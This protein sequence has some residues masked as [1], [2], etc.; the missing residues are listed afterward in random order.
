M[1]QRFQMKLNK[2][3]QL[4]N[5]LTDIVP[6]AL[7]MA[8]YK[9]AQ[10]KASD[11]HPCSVCKKQP[12]GSSAARYHFHG[13]DLGAC[14]K[15]TLHKMQGL[16][17][18]PQGGSSDVFL[19][20]GHANEAEMF[21]YINLGLDPS[22]GIKVIG[23][24]NQDELIYE[25][26]FKDL[27]I[28]FRI[29]GHTDGYILQGGTPV[30]GIECKS[31]KDYTWKKVK[32]GEISDIWYGQIQFYLLATKLEY[33]YLLIKNRGT[34]EFM[35]PIRIEKDLNY[36]KS[37]LSKLMEVQTAL[38]KGTDIPREIKNPSDSQC[39]FCP[40]YCWDND[41]LFAGGID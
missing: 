11:S 27:G 28:S 15:A 29:I 35:L 21:D 19:M 25:K 13:S 34:S 20:D 36:L 22:S 39:K 31:V 16:A 38:V 30:A 8:Y 7:S 18:K 10:M 37:R 24:G 1:I 40:Y 12:L 9:G 14:A 5:N 2:E 32:G 33:W 23:S 3:E 26:K 4:K 17:G 41:S 6:S